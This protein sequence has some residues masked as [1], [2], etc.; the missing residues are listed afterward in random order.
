MFLTVEDQI[1]GSLL[2]AGCGTGETALYFAERGR[3]V[4][5]I[6]FLDVALGR[7]EAK[8]EQR[9][10]SATF[11][12][13]DALALAEWDER[14]DCVIDSGLFHTFSDEQREQYVQGL[15]TVLK[16]PGRLFLA[17]FSDAE[18]DGDFGPRRVTEAELRYAFSDGWRIES[19]QPVRFEVRDDVDLPFSPGG[20]K[21]WLMIVQRV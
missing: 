19:L 17:C 15:A 8:A 1:E 7:A 18:P 14:F 16:R 10:V 2:D 5:G 21:A 3:Q 9:G 4:I 11:L 12:N 20:P 6:D 13:K